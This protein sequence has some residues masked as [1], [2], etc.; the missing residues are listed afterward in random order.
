M[1]VVVGPAEAE[2][3]LAGFLDLGG[4]VAALPVFA[5]GG[6]EEVAG[7]IAADGGDGVVDEVVGVGEAGGFVVEMAF[8]A[9]EVLEVFE[10][11]DG[12]GGVGGGDVEV[13]V[14]VALD[15]EDDAGLAPTDGGF[16]GGGEGGSGNRGGE[17][18]SPGGEE[19]GDGFD[20]EVQHPA[21][22]L[23]KDDG[24]EDA[25]FVDVAAGGVGQRAGAVAGRFQFV[26]L[27]IIG[28]L[29]GVD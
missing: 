3:V 17:G 15:D 19:V 27:V 26:G 21:A 25:V 10:D 7:A 18:R 20:L 23:A 2:A 29:E 11:F 24:G 5:L 1:V 14:A 4:A 28:E 22:V 13:G 6:E 9:A 8:A 12:H 16:A